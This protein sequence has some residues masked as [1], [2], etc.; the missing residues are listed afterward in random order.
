MI[1]F[2]VLVLIFKR[3]C[4]FLGRLCRWSLAENY[5]VRTTLACHDVCCHVYSEACQCS[6]WLSLTVIKCSQTYLVLWKWRTMLRASANSAASWD[7]KQCT[8]N[9]T[10]QPWLPFSKL[11]TLISGK[12]PLWMQGGQHV[13]RIRFRTFLSSADFDSK[14]QVHSGGTTCCLMVNF[15]TLSQQDHLQKA[16]PTPRIIGKHVWWILLAATRV[17]VCGTKDKDTL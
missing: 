2:S 3:V 5:P 10:W 1:L 8:K 4:Y 6:S 12:Y 14:L 17:C 15:S 13:K 9:Q 11:P 7:S 16:Q